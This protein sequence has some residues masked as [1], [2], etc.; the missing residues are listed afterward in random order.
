MAQSVEPCRDIPSPFSGQ[1]FH[2]RKLQETV[3][4][5]FFFKLLFRLLFAFG[6]LF[7]RLSFFFS[8]FL[9]FRILCKH[10]KSLFR[11]LAVFCL[12]CFVLISLDFITARSFV[13]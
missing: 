4:V 11:N 6:L 3:S 9:F 12:V 7:F 8:F 10:L 2:G 5:I 1:S 13:E